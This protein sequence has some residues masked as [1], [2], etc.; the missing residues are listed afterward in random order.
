MDR[1]ATL[2][3]ESEAAELGVTHAYIA[4][5]R[6]EACCYFVWL[7]IGIPLSYIHVCAMRWT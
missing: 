6:H 4:F 7:R 2:G 3:V 1:D 5:P